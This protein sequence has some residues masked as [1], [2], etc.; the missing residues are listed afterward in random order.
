M[1]IIARYIISTHNI[2]GHH[3]GPTYCKKLRDTMLMIAGYIIS[4]H[5]I[6]GH[7]LYIAKDCGHASND[8]GLNNFEIKHCGLPFI[9]CQRL[10]NTMPIIASYIISTHKIAGHHL[11]IAK[12]CG[13]RC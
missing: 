13:T 5:N 8:C 1:P 6:A 2:A 7:H 4:T 3:L 9:Y 11:H 10:R 12:S